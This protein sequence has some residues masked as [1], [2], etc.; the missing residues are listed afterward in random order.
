MLIYE[1]VVPF[2]KGTKQNIPFLIFTNGY[3]PFEKEP[4]FKAFIRTLDI[5]P[6]SKPLERTTMF[7]HNNDSHRNLVLSQQAFLMQNF[8]S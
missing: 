3:V 7:P 2:W 1:N 6:R 5:K 4:I 8:R